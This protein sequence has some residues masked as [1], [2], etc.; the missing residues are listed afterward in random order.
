MA[1]KATRPPSPTSPRALAPAFPAGA[2][3]TTRSSQATIVALIN[4]RRPA[5]FSTSQ[6]ARTP[7]SASAFTCVPAPPGQM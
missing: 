3:A 5:G 4:Q 6:A 1:E 7:P 2:L